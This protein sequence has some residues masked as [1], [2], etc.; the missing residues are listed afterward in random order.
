VCDDARLFG[1]FAE[2][3]SNSGKGTLQNQ[4]VRQMANFNII[5]PCLRSFSWRWMLLILLAAPSMLPAQNKL[6]AQDYQRLMSYVNTYDSQKLLSDPVV[7]PQL[8]RILGP[9]LTHL[10]S[11]VGVHSPLGVDGGGLTPRGNAEHRGGEEEALVFVDLNNG[12]VY[13]CLLTHGRFEVYGKQPKFDYLPDGVRHWVV[14]TGA[15]VNLKGT[16]PPNVVMHPVR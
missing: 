9:Q 10:E 7:K 4:E 8:A 16:Q 15:W 11:N 5:E 12:E 6:S 3:L 2:L 14:L 1:Y 13:A